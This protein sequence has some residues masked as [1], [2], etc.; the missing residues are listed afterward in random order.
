MPFPGIGHI[1]EDEEGYRWL[2]I[3][4]GPVAVDE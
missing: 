3:E 4:F 1:V 2:P